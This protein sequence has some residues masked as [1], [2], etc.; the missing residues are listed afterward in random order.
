[1]PSMGDGA[2]GIDVGFDSQHW[3]AT[4]S[5]VEKELS[6]AERVEGVERLCGGWTSEMRRLDLHGPDGRRS[7]VLRSFVKP[8]YVPARGGPVDPGGGHPAPAR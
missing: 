6:T 5:W 3:G 1:M 2:G 4:R 8:S 7:L